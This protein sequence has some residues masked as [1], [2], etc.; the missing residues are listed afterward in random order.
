MVR[1]R[2]DTR[3]VLQIEKLDVRR[4]ER[5]AIIGPSGCGKTTLLRLINGY[6]DLEAGHLRLLG[7]PVNEGQRRRRATRVR[8]G[9]VFQDFHLVERATVSENVLWGRL[10]RAHPWLS[11][12]GRFSPQDHLAAETAIAEVDLQ[13]KAD[14]RA[15]T[16]SGGQKQ[17]VGVARV[18]AQ[19]P[20][21]ILADEPVSNLDPTLV[22]EILE[23]LAEVGARHR[24]TLL[25][26]LHQPA[27]ARRY[28]QRVI[29]LRRGE[30]VF[31]AEPAALDD[32]ALRL[33]YGREDVGSDR[34]FVRH[35]T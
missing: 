26:T 8:V 5:V 10:G 4:G 35:Q 27:L 7:E 25:T 22:D 21:I 18:L 3:P 17:R 13:D 15:D 32:A 14:Q 16:L 1:Y 29:G 6:V 2:A 33:I 12:L 28:A 20:D 19:Q 11:L 34:L 31:D 30:I 9:F 24:A 23:L